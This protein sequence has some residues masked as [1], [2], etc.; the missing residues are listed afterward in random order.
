MKSGKTGIAAITCRA[1]VP[2]RREKADSSAVVLLG[3]V[4]GYYGKRN[5]MPYIKPADREKFEPV[6]ASLQQVKIN[7]SGELNFVL[8][9]VIH[10]YLG[11]SPNYGAFNDAIGALEGAKL[12]V[13]RR[14][15]APYEDKKILENGDV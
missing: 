9:K 2:R 8:T 10:H 6:L 4:R 13:Y 14:H 15:V 5:A 12:E 11:A 1:A 7:S 3:S